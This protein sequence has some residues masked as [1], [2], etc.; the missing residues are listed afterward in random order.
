MMKGFGEGRGGER[1]WGGGGGR[2]HAEAGPEGQRGGGGAWKCIVLGGV[3]SCLK[4]RGEG[5]W[6]ARTWPACLP[7]RPHPLCAPSHPPAGQLGRGAAAGEAGRAAGQDRGAEGRTAAAAGRA[8]GKGARLRRAHTQ[9]RPGSAPVRTLIAVLCIGRQTRRIS[10]AHACTSIPPPHTHTA[11]HLPDPPPQVSDIEELKRRV[12]AAQLAA[13]EVAQLEAR[14]SALS[15]VAARLPVLRTQYD[16]LQA[17]CAEVR[18]PAGRQ[19]GPGRGGPAAN[20]NAEEGT[21]PV[22]RC[23]CLQACGLRVHTGD[24]GGSAGLGQHSCTM[25]QRTQRQQ[26]YLVVRMGPK[27][28]PRAGRLHLGWAPRPTLLLLPPTQPCVCTP[29]PLLII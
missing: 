5:T 20:R 10:V 21:G 1:E 25:R 12:E 27:P 23:V 26:Q 2:G 19:P 24:V 7:E 6:P 14:F 3:V 16:K 13:G 22:F 29:A 18:R 9:A 4:D 15:S 17:S 28:W 11:F 8:A